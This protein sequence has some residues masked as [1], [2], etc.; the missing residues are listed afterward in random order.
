MSLGTRWA[1]ICSVLAAVSH[2]CDEAAV[3]MSAAA[4]GTRAGGVNDAG[5]YK[6]CT[7]PLLMVDV[8]LN[9]PCHE[10]WHEPGHALGRDMQRASR[11]LAHV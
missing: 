11:R 10:L 9:G 7:L 5:S 2:M 8:L 4:V 3:G 6:F 1:A